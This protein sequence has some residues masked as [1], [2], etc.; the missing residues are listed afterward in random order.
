MLP[1]SNNIDAVIFDVG[2]VLAKN[3]WEHM[4]PALAEWYGLD[5]AEVDEAG[6]LLWETFAYV[7]ETPGNLRGDMEVR[8]WK[9]FLS[10]F[11]RPL[12]GEDISVDSLIALTD[13]FIVPVEGMAPILEAL[14]SRGTT[15]VIC[16]NN[17]EFWQP[18]QMEKLGLQ[19]FFPDSKAILST[20]VG[21]PKDSPGF[22]MF[23]AAVAA[24]G[25]PASRCLFIDDR[26]EN[27]KRAREFGIDAILFKDAADLTFELSERGV[28]L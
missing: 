26:P 13:D 22:E 4:L 7:G 21:A 25:V 8:Y 20:R 6:K 1:R 27:V 15:L 9:L 19:R 14:K 18:R 3:M 10:I 12:L 16:S 23:R 2:G 11:R 24:A 28:V 5:R 17:N